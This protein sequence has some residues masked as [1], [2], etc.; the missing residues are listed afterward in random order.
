MLAVR[1]LQSALAALAQTKIPITKTDVMIDLDK[2]LAEAT[3]MKSG[4]DNKIRYQLNTIIIQI[5]L[6]KAAIR[7][8]NYEKAKE[9]LSSVINDAKNL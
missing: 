1:H 9:I 8:K 7:S 3:S 2:F 6:I 5:G 4:A